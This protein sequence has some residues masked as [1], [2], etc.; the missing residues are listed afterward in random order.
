MERLKETVR[1]VVGHEA[2]LPLSGSFDRNKPRHRS[3]SARN[4][5]LL[6]CFDR[7]DQ[8]GK[9]GLR[10]VHLHVFHVTSLKIWSGSVNQ[11]DQ[12]VTT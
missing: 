11:A 1:N 8:R 12:Q 10:V 7:S 9:V 2:K 4:N 6:A 3:I 5:D